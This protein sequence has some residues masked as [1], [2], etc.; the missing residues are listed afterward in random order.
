MTHKKEKVYRNHIF[1]KKFRFIGSKIGF[2]KM[3]LEQKNFIFLFFFDKINSR[4]VKNNFVIDVTNQVT[5]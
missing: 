1:A 2:S 4:F 5:F 3:H